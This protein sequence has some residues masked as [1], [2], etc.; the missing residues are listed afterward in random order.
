MNNANEKSQLFTNDNLKTTKEKLISDN[1]KFDSTKCFYDTS[2]LYWSFKN[3]T[4][5]TINIH[6]CGEIY[7]IARENKNS[8]TISD[9]I[10]YKAIE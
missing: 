6:G 5:D 7:E 4:K 10:E 8:K 3:Y 9:W 2:S 1:T